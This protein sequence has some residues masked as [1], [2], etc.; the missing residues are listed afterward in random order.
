MLPKNYSKSLQIGD[1]DLSAS[2]SP[3]CFF[4]PNYG[5]Q[6]EV[7][8]NGSGKIYLHTKTVAMETATEVD[9]DALLSLVRITPC[10]RCGKPAF[11]PATGLAD[12]GGL[13]EDCFIHDMRV[14]VE[15]ANE[16]QK[17]V[18]AKRDLAMKE[19]GFTHKVSAHIHPEDGGDDYL[20]VMHVT[21]EPSPEQI[22]NHVQKK[23]SA[24]LSD[25]TI[26]A[27]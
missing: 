25:F 18:E 16:K 19:K 3:C 20:M 26:L 7:V 21:A 5:L 13:C 17:S 15:K 8:L 9:V 14:R 11:A 2:V 4:Y 22:R 24:V 23:R 1:A 6:L 10:S 27:L 12:R